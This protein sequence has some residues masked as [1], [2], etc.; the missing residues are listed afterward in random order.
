LIPFPHNGSVR[1]YLLTFILVFLSAQAFAKKKVTPLPTPPSATKTDG[2]Y[3]SALAVANRF[4]QAWQTQD[5]ES[6]LMMLSD[7]AKNQTS[8]DRLEKYFS[9]DATTPRAYQITHGQKLKTG[10]YRF[11]VA[12]LEL[13]TGRVP[14][15]RNS[16]LIVIQ[17][18]KDDWAVD[19]LP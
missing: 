2:N 11:P 15:T 3:V 8:I 9:P 16:Q 18:G 4:L 19:K 1:I 6:G 10:R 12:L 17:T 14:R 5:H 13:K 7:A